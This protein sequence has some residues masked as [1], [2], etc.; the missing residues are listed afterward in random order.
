M[1]VVLQGFNNFALAYLDDFLVFSSTHLSV[2]I[3][4]TLIVIATL[5]NWNFWKLETGTMDSLLAC[6]SVFVCMRACMHV[7]VKLEN[8]IEFQ[9]WGS[10]HIHMLHWLENAPVSVGKTV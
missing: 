6:M 8:R 9:H 5:T 2:I 7:C 10:P 3:D 1:S 4:K